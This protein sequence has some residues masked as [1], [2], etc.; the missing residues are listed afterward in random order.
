M[1]ASG[2]R[3]GVGQLRGPRSSAAT[4]A[5]PHDPPARIPSSRVSRRAAA[6]ASRSLTR[7]QRSTDGRVVRAG[8]EVLADALG[9]VRPGGVARQDGALRIRADDDDRRVLRLQV[10]GRAGDR[11]A[12]PDAGDEVGHPPLGLVPDLGAGRPL[13][14]VRVLLVPVLVRLERAGDVAGEP[15]GHGVVALRRLR[16]RRWSGR[17]RPRRRT[18]GGAA[19]SRSTACRP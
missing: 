9:Q 13:V 17:G 2:P 6:N 16:A 7:T 11:A 15:G 14:G 5:V 4:R 3:A 10:A 19:A 1:T 12:G 18:R 8:E